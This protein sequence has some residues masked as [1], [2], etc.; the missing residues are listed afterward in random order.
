MQMEIHCRCCLWLEFV[1]ARLVAIVS[2][3]FE[4]NSR[5][6][7]KPYQPTCPP[8]SVAPSLHRHAQFND[9]AIGKIAQFNNFLF[10]F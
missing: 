3:G 4:F 9:F 1:N 2:I 10:I 5:C 8:L 6:S 7:L